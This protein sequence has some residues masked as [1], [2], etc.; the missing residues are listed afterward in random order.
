M[1][2]TGK[3]RASMKVLKNKMWNAKIPLSCVEMDNTTKAEMCS[4]SAYS[5]TK[6]PIC[7]PPTHR[8]N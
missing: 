8:Q 7:Y 6:S 5:C 1:W 3:F 2:H 4:I